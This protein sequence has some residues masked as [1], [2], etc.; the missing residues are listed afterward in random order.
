MYNM[1]NII[2]LVSFCSEGT[3]ANATDEL[4]IPCSIML[5]SSR[6]TAETTVHHRKTIIS[7]KSLLKCATKRLRDYEILLDED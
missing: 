5:V 7:H 1:I 2:S 6:Y 3:E 4:S